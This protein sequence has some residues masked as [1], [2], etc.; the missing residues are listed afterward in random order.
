MELQLQA[1]WNRNCENQ[2][3]SFF[4]FTSDS[5]TCNQ[6]CMG[7]LESE[8]QAEESINHMAYSQSI[9][10]IFRMENM[11]AFHHFSVSIILIHTWSK[12]S[13]DSRL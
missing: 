3:I 5:V 9:Y 8:E 10:E 7:S 12:D 6:V 13:S 4:F 11:V 1:Q 2:N